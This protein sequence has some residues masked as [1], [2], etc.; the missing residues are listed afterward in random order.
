M[1]V[2]VGSRLVDRRAAVAAVLRQERCDQLAFVQRQ[3]TRAGASLY[4]RC[5]VPTHEAR[6]RT[7]RAIGARWILAVV[8]RVCP[9]FVRWSLQNELIF[10]A[11]LTK[12]AI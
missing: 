5:M 11:N 4:Q 8:P 1:P 3:P 12:A 6:R 10:Q 7:T 2:V 9:N